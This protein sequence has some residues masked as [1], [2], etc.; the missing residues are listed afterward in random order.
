MLT[1]SLSVFCK[2][3]FSRTIE[4][5]NIES[6]VN[7][8]GCFAKKRSPTRAFLHSLFNSHATLTTQYAQL[9]RHG[10]SLN[11]TQSSIENHLGDDSACENAKLIMQENENLFKLS[12]EKVEFGNTGKKK[13]QNNL[14]IHMGDDLLRFHLPLS[15]QPGFDCVA[16]ETIPEDLFSPLIPLLRYIGPSHLIR[17]LSALLCERRIILISKSIT[18]LSMCVRA[19][20]SIL[21][22]GL[23]QWRHIL[24]PV[25]PPHMIK[26]LSVKSP[27]LVGILY[28]YAP[29]I[30]SI[31]GLSDVFCVNVDTNE[32]NTVNMAN[33]RITVPDMLKKNN[34]KTE[35]AS[36]VEMLAND[37]EEIFLAD[38]KLWQHDGKVSGGKNEKQ[39]EIGLKAFDYSAESVTSENAATSGS[40]SKRNLFGKLTKQPSKSGSSTKKFMSL[41]EKRQYATSLDAAVAFGKMIRSNCSK[42][43]GEQLNGYKSTTQEEEFVAP[44]YSSPSLEILGDIGSIEACTVAEN[45]GGEENVRAAL[46]CFFIHL[47]GDMGMYLS[48]TMGEVDLL[49]KC[50]NLLRLLLMLFLLL[51]RDILVRSQEVSPS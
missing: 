44:K 35:A 28:Q 1:S 46:T 42:E 36:A 23:L 26:F 15:L 12:V 10:L 5:I 24:I 37:L 19:A 17:L 39:D 45:E 14:N 41:E 9:R 4:A 32:L 22:Q 27:F 18:R 43:S 51:F 40:G 47:Y 25:L 16:T 6:Q 2:H 33:P 7:T 31:E 8:R 50:C 48:E 11:F 3:L 13:I 21:A 34:R 20:S 38:Q 30:K 29:R 49:W